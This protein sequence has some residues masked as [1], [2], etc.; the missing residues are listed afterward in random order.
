MLILPPSPHPPFLDFIADICHSSKKSSPLSR[1][2]P[3]E[4]D[5]GL[6][7]SLSRRTGTGRFPRGCRGSKVG[8]RI[9]GRRICRCCPTLA[10]TRRI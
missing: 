1:K 9:C 2:D 10:Q 7:F 4:K 6:M 5:P 3:T 8:S